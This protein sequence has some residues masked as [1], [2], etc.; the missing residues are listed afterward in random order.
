MHVF[1]R[2][3]LLAALFASIV[4]PFIT[5]TQY[6]EVAPTQ[7]FVLI[8]PLEFTTTEAF[9]SKTTTTWQDYISTVLWIVYFIGVVLFSFRFS[10]NLKTILHKIKANPKH[11]YHSFTNVLLQDLIPPHT[12]FN[13]IFLNKNKYEH[14]LIP[15]EVLLHEQT[16][17]RQKHALDI[18]IIELLQIAFWFNPLIYLIKKDIKLNH[19]F[20]ADQTVINK[21]I[22]VIQYKQTLLAF[23]SHANEPTLANAINYSLIK[24]RF[25]VMKTQT[26]K[27]AFWL[28]GLIILPML[29]I[30]IYGF[31]EKKIVEKQVPNNI[32]NQNTI[33]KNEIKIFIDKHH[34]IFIN[35][36]LID[37]NS[38]SKKLIELSST[39]SNNKPIKASVFINIDGHLTNEFLQQIKNE[40]KKSKLQIS[41]IQANSISLDENKF[42]KDNDE[43]L[44]GTQFTA[45]SI[46]VQTKKEEI[47]TGVS[48]PKKV[49][50][51]K[52]NKI[53]ISINLKGELLV[54]SHVCKIENLKSYLKKLTTE[55]NKK[56]E[57]EIKTY[58]N[59]PNDVI[60][61]VKNILRD[62]KVLKVNFNKLPSFTNKQKKATPK[63]IAE[64]NKLAKK[65]NA[66]S[67][68]NVNIKNKEV[69]RINYLYRIMSVEQR[70][71][72]EPLPVF[73]PPPP[74]AP[75]PKI[76]ETIEVLPPPPPPHKNATKEQ[77]ENYKKIIALHA[78]KNSKAKIVEV[79]QQQF[80]YLTT[81]S[82]KQFEIVLSDGTK[83]FLDSDSKLKY[84]L[85]FIKGQT[86]KVELTYGEAFFDVANSD[87][88]QNS[89]FIVIANGVEIDASKNKSIKK[90]ERKN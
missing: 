90:K 13:Y 35:D 51:Q 65:Y 81:P 59:T 85:K 68:G 60:N 83:V 14:N 62:L 45:D 5:F 44:K 37:F 26:S 19:E 71:K 70:K 15:N 41:L 87:E 3:Y 29:A 42:D 58:T 2:F 75:A 33:S 17:A 9:T 61:K 46:Y 69:K 56:P 79:P 6:I 78:K 36:E 76:I 4:I 8:P 43:Y 54:N 18:I 21:G 12:F 31:S 27:R 20:L 28:R 25:T 32:E 73:P 22:N 66:M 24:K 63:Q 50:H 80:N 57:V 88:Y 74:V 67:Q 52:T 89:S 38:L 7:D 72:A 84:P 47:I 77:K 11:K 55:K 39:P 23:S 10:L 34:K 1:K 48:T 53:Q 86:R 64:Y 82:D 40:V 30:L 16:H 49:Q